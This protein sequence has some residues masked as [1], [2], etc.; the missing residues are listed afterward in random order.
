[1]KSK[2]EELAELIES[3]PECTFHIDNDCWWI[4]G[5]DGETEIASS[6]SHWF[7]EDWYG[8]SNTY[9]AGLAIAMIKILN[10][11]GFKIQSTSV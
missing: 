8:D 9:G 2:S 7:D 4:V 6:G 10:K 5:A 3:N 11:R 1:M